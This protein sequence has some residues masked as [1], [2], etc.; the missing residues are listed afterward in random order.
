MKY[1]FLIF[2]ILILFVRNK[3]FLNH[4]SSLSESSDT[5]SENLIKEMML[6]LLDSYN[7]S[8]S[9]PNLNTDQ[10]SN[11]LNMFDLLKNVKNSDATLDKDNNEQME[12]LL[13][14]IS[15]MSNIEI[16]TNPEGNK[17]LDLS[18]LLSLMTAIIQMK[19]LAG[20]MN[21]ES[22]DSSTDQNMEFLNKFLTEFSNNGKLDMNSIS[23]QIKDMLK[24]ED[25]NKNMKDVSN[26]NDQDNTGIIIIGCIIFFIL[27][28]FILILIRR[29]KLQ[30]KLMN[31]ET[32]EKRGL[33]N[34]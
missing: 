14:M 26:T 7:S 16:T 8:N 10:L 32:I 33:A 19:D 31:Y 18:K 12:T 29:H 21:P 22:K 3:D 30:K 11:I 25:F 6:K 17:N 23:K 28:V 1:F 4:H 34:K 5:S 13:Q 24:D 2:S 15:S 27:A 20:K 9:T